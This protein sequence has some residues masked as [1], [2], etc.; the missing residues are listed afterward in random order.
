[1]WF[2]QHKTRS[3]RKVTRRFGRIFVVPVIWALAVLLAP[4]A[5]ADA[6]T[7]QVVGRFNAQTHV[8]ADPAARPPLQNPDRLNDQILTTRWAWSSAPRL[9]VAGVSVT[10]GGPAV[11]S[12]VGTAK[13]TSWTW[14][15]VMLI[16][17]GLVLAIWLM[18]SRN[19]K[20]RKDA[21]ARD[22]VKE[23][24][25]AVES[26]VADLDSAVITNADTDVSAESLKANSGLSDARKAYQ[27]G[28]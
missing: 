3:R 9:W 24:L 14:L 13:H 22:H 7:D 10:S 11:T 2:D 8:V 27:A 6:Y 23:Q 12:P 17:V 15:W 4:S 16:F 5:W 20:R 28:D 26:E 18:V 19:R 1:M 25:I 21:E